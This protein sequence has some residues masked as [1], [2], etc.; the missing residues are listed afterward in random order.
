[1]DVYN[2]QLHAQEINK[3]KGLAAEFAKELGISVQEAEARLLAQAQQNVDKSFATEHS[4]VDARAA[5]FLRGQAGFF[6]DESGRQML[7]FAPGSKE[8]YENPG[9]YGNTWSQFTAEQQEM[10][11]AASSKNQAQ[12]ES[13]IWDSTKSTA[14]GGLGKGIGNYPSDA[15][16]GLSDFVKQFFHLD[17]VGDEVV[18]VPFDFKNEVERDIAKGTQQ[19]IDNAIQTVGA[20]WASVRTG[21]SRGT[22]GT[23]EQT[24]NGTTRE[25]PA[26]SANARVGLREDLAVQAGIPRSLDKVWGSSID[27]L[28]RAYKMD[29]AT[30]SPSIRSGT[31]GRAQAYTVEGHP[32]ISEIQYHPG[33][34]RHKSG[35]YYKFTYKDGTEVRVIDPASGFKS[36]TITSYQKYYDPKGNRLKYE[37][38]KWS[39]WE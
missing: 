16:N 4:M 34:G 18:G 35:E 15:V 17:G 39:A 3:I 29:G 36:G 37:A 19:L 26:T 9:M 22:G 31:S 32:V 21:A 12:K 7:M 28:I 27:D 13:E 2:R 1:M 10:L 6:V 24:V 30:L 11:N 23:A 33:G 14:L 25:I 5:D 38:G 8:A 20:A